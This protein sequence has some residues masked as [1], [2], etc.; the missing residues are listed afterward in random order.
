MLHLAFEV[1][2][3]SY[4]RERVGYLEPEGSTQCTVWHKKAIYVLFH[5][6][7]FAHNCNMAPHTEVWPN[8]GLNCEIPHAEI[9]TNNYWGWLRHPQPHEA[10]GANNC[11]GRA[12]GQNGFEEA[13]TIHLCLR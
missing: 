5:F 9:H 12:K 4:R 10:F 6:V 13:A 7:A 8:E 2:A 3:P 1:G 11:R